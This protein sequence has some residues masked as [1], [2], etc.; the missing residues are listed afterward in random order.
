MTDKPIS[1]PSK[2]YSDH[3]PDYH[4]VRDASVRGAGAGSFGSCCED[5]IA[6]GFYCTARPT[7]YSC[8]LRIGSHGW[9]VLSLFVIVADLGL[10]MASVQRRQLSVDELSTLFWINVVG[11]VMLA[12]LTIAS[13]PLLVLIFDEPRVIGAAAAL[14]LTLVA[15]GIGTQH[16]AVLR[17]RLSYSFLHVSGIASQT[18]AL[19]VALVSA[20]AGASYWALILQQVVAQVSRVTMLWAKTRWRPRRPGSFVDVLPMLSYGSR[21][22]PAHLLAHTARSFGEII[23]GAGA[24]AAELGQFRRAHGMAA[25]VEETRLPL[26]PIVPASLSRLQDRGR[27]FAR[28][29]L[30]AISVSSFAGCGIV[31]WLAAEAPAAVVIVLGDQWLGAI[32]LIRWLAPAGLALAL[33]IATEWLLMPLGHM[34]RL[35]ALRAARLG[36]IVVGVLVGWRWGVIGVAAGYSGAACISV[37]LELVG[38]TARTTVAVRRLTVAVVR[39]ILAAVGAGYL[40]YRIQS[41]VSIIS[42]LLELLCY[43]V[44]YTTL[45]TALPGGWAVTHSLLRAVRRTLG[46]RTARL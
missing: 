17:R 4:H 21:L 30:H 11:G 22:V 35:L 38:A 25:L 10:H 27:E 40:V 14:S 46:A 13:A 6:T 26:K 24:G 39:P 15:I 20:L 12:S 5:A 36:I 45:H 23:V 44:V 37:G 16:E 34:R 2:G 1:Q 8:G 31:G 42:L 43:V 28:F 29:Y 19:S 33:G 7:A 3:E 18:L 41:P 9:T 32:P